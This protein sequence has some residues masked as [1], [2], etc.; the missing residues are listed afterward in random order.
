MQMDEYNQKGDT[1]ETDFEKFWKEFSEWWPLDGGEEEVTLKKGKREYRLRCRWGR[2]TLLIGMSAPWVCEWDYVQ[3]Y[4]G[5]FGLGDVGKGFHSK[6]L[7]K[8]VVPLLLAKIVQR[9]DWLS[10]TPRAVAERERAIKRDVV[11]ADKAVRK[12]QGKLDDLAAR[13]GDMTE[14]QF[15]RKRKILEECLSEEKY[16]LNMLSKPWFARYR[17]TRKRVTGEGE[18]DLRLY[19]KGDNHIWGDKIHCEWTIESMRNRKSEDSV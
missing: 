14:T 18:G 16:E 10:A 15:S 4:R 7:R 11:A 6:T 17:W 8:K 9:Q 1:V 13:R 2:G 12:I 19:V 3:L 5:M